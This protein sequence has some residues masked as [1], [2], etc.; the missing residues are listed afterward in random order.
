MSVSGYVPICAGALEGLK[1]VTDDSLVGVT[2]G[3][4]PV[5]LGSRN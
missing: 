2:G 1:K 5:C 4:E 3:G